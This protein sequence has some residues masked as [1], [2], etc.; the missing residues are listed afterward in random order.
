MTLSTSTNTVQY[1][2]TSSQTDFTIPYK[3]FEDSDIKVLH[4]QSGTETLITSGFSIV[5][6]TDTGATLRFDAGLN[7]GTKVRI[8]RIVPETQTLDLATTGVFPA[9]SVETSLDRLAAQMQQALGRNT[10]DGTTMDAES[11]R[12]VNVTDGSASGDA[13]NKSQLDAITTRVL[14][15]EQA[16]NIGEGSSLNV[17]SPSGQANNNMLIVTSNAYAVATPTTVRA[18]MSLAT[19]DNVT[20]ANITGTDLTCDG[21]VVLGNGT[22][23]KTVTVNDDLIVAGG[24]IKSTASGNK[25]GVNIDHASADGSVHIIHHSAGAVT[26]AT[27]NAAGDTLV[28]EEDDT[29]AGMSILSPEPAS[30]TQFGNIYFGSPLDNNMGGIVYSHKQNPGSGNGTDDALT[31]RVGGS[32]YATFNKNGS[33]TATLDFGQSTRITGLAEP[34]AS[35]DAATLNTVQQ[36][37][38]FRVA[39][40]ALFAVI[41]PGGPGSRVV[42]ALEISNNVGGGADSYNV[43]LNSTSWI[44]VDPSNNKFTL[45]PGTYK[46]DCTGGL[47]IGDATGFGDGPTFIQEIGPFLASS[48]SGG[49]TGGSGAITAVPNVI[50][51][52]G[53]HSL[54]PREGMRQNSSG[55]SAPANGR[56]VLEGF[57]LGIQGQ[58]GTGRSVIGISGVCTFAGTQAVFPRHIYQ[59]PQSSSSTGLCVGYKLIV[60]KL[61]GNV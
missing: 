39:E 49:A 2:A 26:G 16:A 9:E 48:A 13:V 30:A 12:I 25:I 36:L 58:N 37:A 14:A 7:S 29:N 60:T 28:I 35:T 57:A 18:N 6:K 38:G 45:Q 47:L 53:G 20:F 54:T 31:V 15:V 3:F 1:T 40:F 19:S 52:D 8:N 61:D 41:N 27:A 56:N 50:I 32:S 22:G 5:D 23:P 17:P 4:D 33:S 11:L 51:D 42:S 46:F 24:Q 44:T 59:D 34:S 21:N 43:F 55:L 10:T